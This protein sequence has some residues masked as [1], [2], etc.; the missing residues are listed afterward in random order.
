MSAGHRL[1]PQVLAVP[2]SSTDSGRRW[3][4]GQE[5]ELGPAQTTWASSPCLWASPPGLG[6][7]RRQEA[8]LVRIPVPGTRFDSWLCRG[9]GGCCNKVPKPGDLQ[10]QRFILSAWRPGLKAWCRGASPPESRRDLLPALAVGWTV[11]LVLWLSDAPP[12]PWSRGTL[13]MCLCLHVAFV[14]GS[15]SQGIGLLTPLL[16]V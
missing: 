14:C 13:H 10:P 3:T 5:T 12:P 6:G 7:G 2:G 16:R 8:G 9:E 4:S 11:K 15:Q 1:H